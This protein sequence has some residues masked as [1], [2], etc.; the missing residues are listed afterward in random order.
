MYALI[1]FDTEDFISPPD[2]PVHTLPGQLAD[3]MHKHGLVGCFH[4]IGEKARFM[5]RHGLRDAIDSLRRHDISL[6]FD[7][8]SIHPTTAEEVSELDWFRGVE[9]MLFREVP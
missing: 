8:G 3:I 7:R 1:Y 9:R 4:I 6:H 2:S 5:E